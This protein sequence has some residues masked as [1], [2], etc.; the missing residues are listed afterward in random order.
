MGDAGSESVVRSVSSVSNILGVGAC[1][2]NGC[3][4]AEHLAKSV[5]AALDA[6]GTDLAS[7]YPQKSASDAN[8]E[9]G[10]ETS[11]FHKDDGAG[12]GGNDGDDMKFSCMFEAVEGNSIFDNALNNKT[13]ECK[14][15]EDEEWGEGRG[16]DVEERKQCMK[17]VEGMGRIS[18]F[19]Y[20]SLNIV[21]SRIVQQ[22]FSK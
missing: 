6:A 9:M 16:E 14:A 3:A 21:F 15:V 19:F 11:S 20:A 10:N 8:N 18:Q 22:L 4:T 17:G 5:G 13:S 7:S 1:D 2:P 12:L